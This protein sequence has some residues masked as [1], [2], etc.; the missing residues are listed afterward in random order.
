MRVRRP[1]ATTFVHRAKSSCDRHTRAARSSGC[2]NTITG[3][4]QSD[5]NRTPRE[6][7][8]PNYA[9]RAIGS[10]KRVLRASVSAMTHNSATHDNN[11]RHTRVDWIAAAAIVAAIV[12]VVRLAT[13]A[14][15]PARQRPDG[16][17][18]HR[19]DDG[20]AVRGQPVLGRG[21]SR[22]PSR[23]PR[24]RNARNFFS[25]RAITRRRCFFGCF[26]FSF[27]RFNR[28]TQPPTRRTGLT[29]Y[30]FRPRTL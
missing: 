12:V 20:R 25:F 5:R 2:E 21:A 4:R 9:T 13:A 16:P 11:V 8:K 7:E 29:H 27:S 3:Q 19:Q 23:A 6:Q 28:V 15:L 18:H 22:P 1:S 26:F 17:R 30:V 14:V 10:G 24:W